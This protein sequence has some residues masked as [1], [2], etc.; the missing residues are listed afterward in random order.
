MTAADVAKDVQVVKGQTSLPRRSTITSSWLTSADGRAVVFVHRL[1]VEA[2]PWKADKFLAAVRTN[3]L[4]RACSNRG[5]PKA[6]NQRVV[7]RYQYADLVR[8]N[9]GWFDIGGN[10]CAGI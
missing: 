7:F 2:N 9:V 10:D 6:K 1:T 4:R 8:F 3:M 5:M